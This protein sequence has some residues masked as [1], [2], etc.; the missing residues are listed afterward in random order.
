M[1]SVNA[2][3]RKKK[4]NDEEKITEIIKAGM[5]EKH[6]REIMQP[7]FCG[8]IGFASFN[9]TN[10]N[11]NIN[12]IKERIEHLE[13]QAARG[14]SAKEIGT[15]KIIENVEENRC[16]IFF[17][18]KPSEECRTELKSSG[19]RWSPYNGCWQRHRSNQASWLAESIVKKFYA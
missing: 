8:R 15:V 18:D 6:A 14:S 1:K 5:S 10:N 7:D 3:I 9:L 19:F 11:A 16:Q 4:L 17:P 12:R 13:K 2:I